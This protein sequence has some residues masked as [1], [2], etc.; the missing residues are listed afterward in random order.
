M[1]NGK[2]CCEKPEA[3]DAFKPCKENFTEGSSLSAHC[4][5]RVIVT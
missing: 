1:Y 4:G 2:E 5:Y 3:E